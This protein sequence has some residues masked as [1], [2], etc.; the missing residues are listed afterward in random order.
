[1]AALIAVDWG[2]T[3]LRAYLLDAAGGVLD[4]RESAAGVLRIE[5]GA[6]EA[7][8]LA[9]IEPWLGDHPAAAILASGMIT[10]RQGWVETAY[11][12]CPAGAAE[13]ALGLMAHGLAEGREIHFVPGLVHD[14]PGDVPDVMRGEQTQ[15]LGAVAGAPEARLMLLPGTHS[16]WTSV[17]DGRVLGFA[18][19]M[20]GEV[21]AVLSEHSILGRM[22]AP[23][24]IIDLDAFRR[25]LDYAWLLGPAGGLLHRLFSAR[26]LALFDQMSDTATSDYLSGLLIGQEV[27]EA[28]AMNA[29]GPVLTVGTPELAIRYG[30]ALDRLGVSS[31]PA[32][33]DVAAAG[34]HAVARAACLI[35]E[36]R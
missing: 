36:E 26:T 15:I 4:S 23:A 17:A 16:K 25:G 20:T 27:A 19:F 22:M 14:G 13:I 33:R 21:F 10:S 34:L 9:E 2:L 11:L 18:T 31:R 29:G 24:K 1:M 30:I 5:G 28:L 8:L 35:G 7:A 12:P 32:P 6:F 3:R